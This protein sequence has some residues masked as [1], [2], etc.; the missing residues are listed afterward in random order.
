[1]ALSAEPSA[2]GPFYDA[3]E[4]GPVARRWN[5]WGSAATRESCESHA[6]GPREAKWRRFQR[7]IDAPHAFQAVVEMPYVDAD[8][9][10]RNDPCV[11]PA[12][13]LLSMLP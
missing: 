9:F 2:G 1:L 4:N 6:D 5:G 7:Q 11:V 13:T 8:P 10:S 12:S 3:C